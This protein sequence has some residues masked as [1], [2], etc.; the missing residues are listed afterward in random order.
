[1]RS[2]KVLEIITSYY[3]ESL[4]SYNALKNFEDFSNTISKDIANILVM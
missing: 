1:M 3:E 4:W 2:V